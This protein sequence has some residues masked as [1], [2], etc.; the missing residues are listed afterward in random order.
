MWPI[1]KLGSSSTFHIIMWFYTAQKKEKRR[2]IYSI[3]TPTV[4]Y[5]HSIST[6]NNNHKKKVENEAVIS[7]LK[8]KYYTQHHY[9]SVE[10]LIMLMMNL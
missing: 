10:G 7:N 1:Y 2:E 8:F 3:H 4:L 9:G 6:T 5:I